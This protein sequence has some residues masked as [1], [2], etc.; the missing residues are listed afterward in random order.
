MNGESQHSAAAVLPDSAPVQNRA[1]LIA[2]L[3][4]GETPRGQWRIGT[5][6]EKIGLQQKGFAPVPY[7]G[8]RGIAA[9][10]QSFADQHGW[11]PVLEGGNI[12]ALAKEGASITL[13]PGGQLEL[14]GAPL[15]RITQTCAEFNAH[16]ELLRR[17][18][19]PLGLVWLA[20]GANPLHSV[21]DAPRMP[22]AR[23]KIMRAY[24]PQRAELPLEMMHL[25]AT[26]QA[27][28][29]FE[30]ESD[31]AQKMRGA[32]TVTPVVSALF[33][34]SP[35]RLG[36][37]S[38]FVSWR[39]HVWRHT[40]SHRCGM[41]PFVF[42]PNFGYAQYVNWALQVPMFFIV[43]AGEYVAA[44]GLPFGEFMRRGL[45]EHRA[46]MADW[47]LHLTTLF[48]EVRCKQFIEVRGADA[49]PPELTCAL[50]ALWKG[51]LYH[52]GALAAATELLPGAS[53]EGLEAALDAVARR[54]LAARVG[55][56]SA[57]ELAREL[58]AIAR[59]SL[60]LQHADSGFG[61]NDESDEVFLDPVGEI[62]ERGQSP[63]EQLLARWEG[64]W[65]RQTE[66]LINAARY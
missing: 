14:S 41:L 29:D 10:L 61:P 3:R 17:V 5:E 27:N 38:G 12:I 54:A 13:E 57:L 7:A 31:M 49:S 46:T 40:D 59:E 33:A 56:H 43:R 47:K 26:V 19:Q 65:G 8:P 4:A 24:L 25:S 45:G 18:S 62:L 23:Y 52:E 1:E 55:R 63:G 66:K 42:Q 34:N 15:K 30:S 53:A 2:Y 32:L 48:P 64:E 6:H 35:F 9:V 60:R 28:F 11:R 58:Y 37:P 21:E 39:M 16:L 44:Q 22:K 50:P 51:I 20:L 36:K